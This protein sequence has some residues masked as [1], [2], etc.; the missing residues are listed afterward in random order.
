MESLLRHWEGLT[1]FVRYPFLPLDNNPAERAHRTP[2]L[3]RKN[4]YGSQALWSAQLAV[5]AFSISQTAQLHGLNPFA[6]L[7][8]YLELCALNGGQPPRDL[9]PF[10]PWVLKETAPHLRLNRGPP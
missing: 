5:M 9:R 1:L 3:G 4:F 2:V 7:R 10:L 8:H 6:Y